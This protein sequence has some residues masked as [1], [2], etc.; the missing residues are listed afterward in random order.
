MKSP[1]ILSALA[2]TLALTMQKP[3]IALAETNPE[4]TTESLATQLLVAIIQ[5]RDSFIA[6]A[7]NADHTQTAIDAILYVLGS[8]K[9]KVESFGDTGNY[10]LKFKVLDRDALLSEGI[11][12]EKNE[13]ITEEVTVRI[14]NLNNQQAAGVPTSIYLQ[15]GS[16]GGFYKLGG[17]MPAESYK[18]L[19]AV[20]DCPN[21]PHGCDFPVNWKQNL[22]K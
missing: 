21:S 7:Q 6:K 5:I 1:Q 15:Y 18:M 13:K 12:D 20:A 17:A 4:I 8:R 2:V 16:D 3:N 9:G 14:F 22:I 11:A 10:E 19:T